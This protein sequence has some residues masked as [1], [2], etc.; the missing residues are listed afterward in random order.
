MDVYL[1]HLGLSSLRYEF[2][3]LLWL[4]AS[5]V[6]T[7]SC[8]SF[9]F[10]KKKKINLLSC[11]GP[12]ARAAWIRFGQAQSCLVWF[13]NQPAADCFDH[14]THDTEFPCHVV[15]PRPR[16]RREDDA[17]WTLPPR[18]PPRA[19]SGKGA[20]GGA[21]EASERTNRASARRRGRGWFACGGGAKHSGE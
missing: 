4:C 8:T 20:A 5:L 16:C 10:L 17:G 7:E 18:Q 9:F 14:P 21:E 1:Y 11:L 3:C 13:G 12:T 6:G 15:C 2:E 19:I